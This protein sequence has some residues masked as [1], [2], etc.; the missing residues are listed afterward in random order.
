MTTHAEWQADVF[1]CLVGNL[2]QHS[3]EV[4]HKGQIRAKLVK[5]RWQRANKSSERRQREKSEGP[6]GWWW[7]VGVGGSGLRRDDE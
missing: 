6:S 2:S 5:G 1:G 4:E 3:G 7:W